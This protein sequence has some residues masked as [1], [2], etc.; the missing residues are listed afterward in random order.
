MHACRPRPTGHALRHACVL[1]T[2]THAGQV[3]TRRRRGQYGRC[4]QT[5]RASD[6]QLERIRREETV[7]RAAF[8]LRERVH[9]PVAS[10]RADTLAKPRIWRGMRAGPDVQSH[11]RHRKFEAAML[12]GSL[13]CAELMCTARSGHRVL[14]GTCPVTVILA[15]PHACALERPVHA[16]GFSPD[17]TAQTKYTHR[18]SCPNLA[19]GER[20]AQAQV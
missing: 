18:T 10:C 6:R 2:C 19:S 13:P 5:P 20:A 17:L 7:W 12:N 16:C 8:V 14:P 11:Q 3:V 1:D 4:Q 15:A 9:S